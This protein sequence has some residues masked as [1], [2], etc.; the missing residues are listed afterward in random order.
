MSP[1]LREQA[2]VHV[3]KHPGS[4]VLGRF[5]RRLLIHELGAP[6]LQKSRQTFLEVTKAEGGVVE[7][8][9]VRHAGIEVG[10]LG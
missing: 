3:T 8:L 4:A 9:L 5:T 7:G 10:V 1:N 6:L 2:K